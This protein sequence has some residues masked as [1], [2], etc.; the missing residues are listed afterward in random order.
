MD[1]P[2]IIWGCL[3]AQQHLDAARRLLRVHEVHNQ[4]QNAF[5][6]DMA[7]K[8]PLLSHQWPLVVKFRCVRQCC[9]IGMFWCLLLRECS[10]LLTLCLC[11]TQFMELQLFDEPPSNTGLAQAP[12]ALR[13][14]TGLMHILI[15][16]VPAPP[17]RPTIGNKFLRLPHQLSAASLS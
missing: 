1:T 12:V 7:A 6:A 2:E 8:F 10:L 5:A 17:L 14:N 13:C 15:V 16:A 9:C 4:L 11:R 3:E